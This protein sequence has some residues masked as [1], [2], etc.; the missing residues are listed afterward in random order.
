M[1]IEDDLMQ[2]K[3]ILIRGARGFGWSAYT[4]PGM[5]FVMGADKKK[6]LIE[7]VKYTY[8]EEGFIIEFVDEKDFDEINQ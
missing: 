1:E 5:H 7:A 2:Y 3:K 6:D 4:L 8:K